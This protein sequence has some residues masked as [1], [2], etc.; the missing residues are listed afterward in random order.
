MNL[1]L[2]EQAE[3]DPHA[4]DRQEWV[5]KTWKQQ[6]TGHI[7]DHI[8]K[9]EY[10]LIGSSA[11]QHQP[12]QAMIDVVAPDLAVYRSQLI[13]LYNLNPSI[14]DSA[15]RFKPIGL[16]AIRGLVGIA[17]GAL[18]HYLEPIAHGAE[19]EPVP[20]VEEAV[21]SLHHAALGLMPEGLEVAHAA[22]LEENFR[23]FATS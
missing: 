17:S 6:K 7:R 19:P 11:G 12:T 1:L 2:R 9:A 10:K 22:R 16:I 14:V 20:F 5:Y 8:D 23:R 13:N 15:P 18:A 21:I 4:F 3:F